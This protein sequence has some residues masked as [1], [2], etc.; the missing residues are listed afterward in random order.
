L[1][2]EVEVDLVLRHD[3]VVEGELQEAWVAE[4]EAVLWKWG[5]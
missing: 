5:V 4:A 2:Q 1:L 3:K